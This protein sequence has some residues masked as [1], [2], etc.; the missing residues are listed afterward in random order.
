MVRG[1]A[2]APVEAGAGDRDRHVPGVVADHELHRLAPENTDA[3]QFTAVQ[4]H[5]SETGVVAHGGDDAAGGTADAELLRAGDL[6]GGL[7]AVEHPELDDAGRLPRD[8][9]ITEVFGEAVL[10]VETGA[11]HCQRVE[12]VLLEELVHGL[13]A[14]RRDDFR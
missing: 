4:E 9:A 5:L 3:V 11:V 10:D 13:T 14:C 7:A 1:D 6:L 2:Q 8:V 12:D